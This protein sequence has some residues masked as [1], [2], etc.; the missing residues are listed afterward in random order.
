MPVSRATHYQGTPRFDDG[1]KAP[2]SVHGTDKTGGE[3]A[4]GDT[5]LALDAIGNPLSWM[6]HRDLLEQ[7]LVEL[8]AINMQLSLM[9]DHEIQEEDT[10]V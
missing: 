2:V 10:A 3:Y 8:R 1:D 4:E 7:I 9:T 5:S 6:V